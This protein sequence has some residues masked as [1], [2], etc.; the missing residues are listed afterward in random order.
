M[1]GETP[2]QFLLLQ[3][4]AALLLC[5]CNQHDSCL[6]INM[7]VVGA[8]FTLI[9]LLTN[10]SSPP[11]HPDAPLLS[12]APHKCL[13]SPAP[14]FPFFFLVSFPRLSLSTLYFLGLILHA[15]VSARP[16]LP[17]RP[18]TLPPLVH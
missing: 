1:N 13:L 14:H 6:L 17:P 8:I 12:P 11:L 15:N 3:P 5:G 4:H 9:W 18:P 2:L 10:A 7:P 16:H